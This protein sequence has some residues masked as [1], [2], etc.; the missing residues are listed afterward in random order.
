MI[1]TT[2]IENISPDPKAVEHKGREQADLVALN[3][4]LREKKGQNRILGFGV[5]A[6]VWGPEAEREGETG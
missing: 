6:R 5:Q 4:I 2:H 3:N 1:Q